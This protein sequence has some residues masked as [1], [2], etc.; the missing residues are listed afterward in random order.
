[1]VT[2]LGYSPNLFTDGNS[3]IK[4][5]NDLDDLPHIETQEIAV[6]II[7]FW[8]DT[9]NFEIG[10]TRQDFRIRATLQ[11]TF[12]IF[13]SAFTDSDKNQWGSYPSED[14]KKV[15]LLYRMTDVN[16]SAWE[17]IG[18]F[19][20]RP[21]TVTEKIYYYPENVTDKE[22]D[23]GTAVNKMLLLDKSE[24]SFYKQNGDFVFIINCNRKRVI[25]DEQGN[26][27]PAGNS[28]QIGL[29]TEFK[30]FITLEIDGETL[31][32]DW[33]NH[34][35]NVYLKPIRQK[36]KFPQYA[37][38]G[39][40]FRNPAISGAEEDNLAWVKQYFTFCGGG[41]YSLAKFHGLMENH[42]CGWDA[43][44]IT[45][46]GIIEN[47][48]INNACH[49]HTLNN[50]P[51]IQTNDYGYTG[52][53]LTQMCGNSYICCN[54]SGWAGSG[55]TCL[56]GANWLNLS[57]YLPQTGWVYD[58]YSYIYCHRANSQFTFSRKNDTFYMKPNTQQIAGCYFDTC[59]FA[60][61]DVNWTDIICV[62]KGDIMKMY[63][64]DKK[65]FIKNDFAANPLSGTTYR[66][67]IYTPTAHPISWC[68][69]CP[70][71]GGRCNGTCTC[72][73]ADENTYFFKGIDTSDCVAFLVNLGIV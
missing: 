2:N 10:I 69:P 21:G 64:L 56:F 53:S 19:Y 18:A 48:I 59:G 61:S 49:P 70:I 25:M 33:T 30:G 60:R 66:N 37:T 32:L 57:I 47:T 14:D 71:G 28:S 23:E 50:T 8:G 72:N 73:D 5:S 34:G 9:T 17:N 58:N 38:M 12:V 36:L 63:K 4:P 22:I 3:K 67:G 51:I 55:I 46:E 68:A 26:L 35:G 13:G 41:I 39:H 54:N 45:S 62:P 7:P 44:N 27:V 42:R 20:K 43:N 24:Y 29:Y 65:G 1:M 11:N 31:S 40:T 15:C 6:D 16:R 52:N